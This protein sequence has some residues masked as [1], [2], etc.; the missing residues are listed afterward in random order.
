METLLRRSSG[1]TRMPGEMRLGNKLIG[2]AW[3]FSECIESACSKHFE[4][5]SSS[6]VPHIVNGLTLRVTMRCGKPV[7]GISCLRSG[8]V[9]N[10]GFVNS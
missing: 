7:C 1:G 10:S 5:S 8:V 4:V 3:Q 2:S 6:I 9:V